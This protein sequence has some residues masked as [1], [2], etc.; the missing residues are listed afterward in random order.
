[1]PL[2]REVAALALRAGALWGRFIPRVGTWLLSSWLV[3][4]LCLMT[5][6]LLGSHYGALGAVVFVVGV[7]CHV[8]G[9]IL[10]IHELKPGLAS[11]AV[12][13]ASPVSDL[14]VPDAVLV[15][16][17]RVDVAVLTIGPV[18]AV[19][20]VWGLVDVMIRDGMLWNGIIR[21]TW[22]AG[23]WSISRA[24]DRFGLYIALGLA[25]WLG[26]VVYGRLVR[27]RRSPWWRAPLVFLEGL[28]TFA[29]FF[30]ALMG[31]ESAWTWLLQRRVGRAVLVGWHQFVD[32]L[33]PIEIYLDVTLPELVRG[34]VIWLTEQVL[35]G[36]W[37]GIA[38][39]LMWLAL[40]AIVFGWREFRARDLLGRR[41]REQADLLERRHGDL[42][43]TVGRIA[44]LLTADLRDKYVPLLHALRLVWRSGPYVLGAYLMLSAVV[45]WLGDAVARVLQRFLMADSSTNALFSLNGVDAVAH[46]VQFS[47]AICLYAAAFDRGLADTAG[48]AQSEKD[49]L[50]RSSVAVGHTVSVNDAS[51]AGSTM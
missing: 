2:L 3:Y 5:S 44:G 17:H 43:A 42:L 6:A 28:W 45:A 1:M 4:S 40:V 35:P 37:T 24:P 41:A 8:V 46:L 34:G 21:T 30:V 39:P 29:L 25:A 38:L 50:T 23:E 33:P 11:P 13:R 32:S 22:N 7:T 18:L 14:E 48:L 47:L 19:Y 51:G 15:R 9:V 10:A 20:A 36:L 12:V 16:E 31:V 27:S 49:Q 26:K